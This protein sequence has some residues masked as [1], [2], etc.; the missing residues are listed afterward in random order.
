M[1]TMFLFS[2]QGSQYYQM[3]RSLY[4]GDAVF[5]AQLDHHD[6]IVA[7]LLGHSVR[8]VIHDPGRQRSDRFDQTTL[9]GAAICMIELSL[10]ATLAQHGVVADA[11]LGASMGVFAAA[12][13][14]GSLSAEQAL[15]LTVRQGE[16]FE[17]CCAEGLMVAV[18]GPTALYHGT[19]ALRDNSE[20]AALSFDG[21]FVLALPQSAWPVVEDALKRSGE[22][23]QRM[24]VSRAFHSRWIDAAEADFKACVRTLHALPPRIPLV[25][26]APARRLSRV[27]EFSLWQTVRQPIRFQAAVTEVEHEGPWRYIDVGPSSTLATFLKYQLP[28]GSSSSI[29]PVMTLFD[30]DLHHL[31][32]LLPAAGLAA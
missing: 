25:C 9:A 5:K 30:R 8:D 22:T 4:H 16:V 11:V 7:D 29:Q 28:P 27:D 32:K 19:P 24:S 26:C 1:K 2:G 12:V 23:Y 6:E 31:G 18:L 3:G 14:A 17:R 10:A 15:Q 13:V 20:I 21:H